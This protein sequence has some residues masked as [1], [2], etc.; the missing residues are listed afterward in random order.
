MR[1]PEAVG[2]VRLNA[3]RMMA[4]LDKKGVYRVFA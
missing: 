2:I 3:I 4:F 1:H